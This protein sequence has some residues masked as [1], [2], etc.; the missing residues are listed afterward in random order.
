[1]KHLFLFLLV[2]FLALFS[3]AQLSGIKTVGTGKNYTTV[4]GAIAA[5]NSSGVGS[6]GVA[7]EVDAGHTETFSSRTAGLIT[8]SGTVSNP[9]V[10]R[11]SGTGI[12]PRITAPTGTSNDLDGVIIISGG[13]YITFDGIDVQ[14]K[15]GNT[16]AVTRMEWGYG[17]LKANAAD[18]SSNIIIRNCRITL[19]KLNTA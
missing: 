18:G 6:G 14:E 19:N 17:I 7:F 1:M 9:V 8:A 13:D 5:L 3:K 16:T 10:F 12:N 4:A 15:S 2:S 11:K